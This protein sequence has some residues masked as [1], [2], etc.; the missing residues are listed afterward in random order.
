[1]RTYEIEDFTHLIEMGIVDVD[2]L[3]PFSPYLAFLVM[4]AFE[5]ELLDEQYALESQFGKKFN[6]FASGQ[7]DCFDFLDQAMDF[8]VCEQFFKS[9]Y[10]DMI[11]AFMENGANIFAKI[12]YLQFW[13][14][15]PSYDGFRK[16]SDYMNNVYLSYKASPPEEDA[17]W[18]IVLP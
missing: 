16:Y 11:E 14:A 3:E 6:L 1:M 12:G 10:I 13:T 18:G 5:N 9:E 15:D 8:K 2:V 17:P 7:L 4:W